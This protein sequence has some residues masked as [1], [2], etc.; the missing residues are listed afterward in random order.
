VA[1]VGGRDVAGVGDVVTVGV[2][3]LDDRRQQ[4]AHAGQVPQRVARHHLL[5]VDDDEQAHSI[6]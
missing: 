6:V 5:H 3:E 2:G 1:A 4:V